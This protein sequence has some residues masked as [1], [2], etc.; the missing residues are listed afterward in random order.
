MHGIKAEPAP[1]AGGQSWSIWDGRELLDRPTPVFGACAV[2]L[3]TFDGV[4]VGHR[5]ILREAIALARERGWTAVAFT[6]D[7]HPAAT[8]APARRPLLLTSFERKLALILETGVDHV[9]VVR[10][11]REFSRVAAGDFV[12]R[13]LWGAL[14]ARAIVVGRDFRFGSAAGGDV[15]LLDEIAAE[16]GYVL[17]VVPPVT[18]GGEKVSSTTIRAHI[19]SGDV[20]RAARLLGR[21]FALEGIAVGH[22]TRGQA[23][24]RAAKLSV[25]EELIVPAEG[26]YLTRVSCPEAGAALVPSLTVVGARSGPGCGGSSIE[27]HLLDFHGDLE[28]RKLLLEFC[29]RLREAPAVDGAEPPERLFEADVA[30]AR[31]YFGL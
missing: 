13:I 4:H 10:F 29:A 17:R 5:E 12:R 21:P 22:S 27:T 2:A 1:Q 6:F 19:A 24:R 30:R 7:R 25:S 23:L 14:G 8:I 15:T 11:D 3:G 26:V 16:L 18:D 31:A 28:G 20:E 9:V